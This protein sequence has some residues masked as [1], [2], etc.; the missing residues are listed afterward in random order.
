MKAFGLAIFFSLGLLSV[1]AQNIR[2]FNNLEPGA[3]FSKNT[4]Q[5]SVFW[6][7]SIQFRPPVPLRFITG[8]RLSM[9]NKTTGIYPVKEGADLNTL[10]FLKKPWYTSL[11]LPAGLELYFK[12]FAVGAFQEMISF[13]GK[14][15]YND[16]FTPLAENETLKT[17]GFSGIFGKKQNLT[18]GVYLIYT[19]SDSFSVKAGYNRIS[20]TFTRSDE[21]RESGY[22]RLNDDTFTVGIRLN[23][24]K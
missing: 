8:L 10:T 14:K 20:A 3:S 11:A 9:T 15:S 4:A 23:I 22:A 7:E 19:F 17:Q 18:G 16:T 13:S 1:R 5:Y 21:N 6:G 24:E 12:G 2:T